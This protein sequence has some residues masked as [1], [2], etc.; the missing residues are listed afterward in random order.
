MPAVLIVG[1]TLGL[2]LWALPPQDDGVRSALQS[3][4][5]PS[6]LGALSEH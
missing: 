3:L 5:L 2:M 6:H 1:L 4:T